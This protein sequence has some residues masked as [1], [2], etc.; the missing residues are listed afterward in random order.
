[1][2][3]WAE[4]TPRSF[5]FDVKAHP[6]FT[7]HPIDRRRLPS[8]LAQ[9]LPQPI[10]GERLYGTNLPPELAGEIERR[11]F[12]SLAPLIDVARLS[13][14]LVQFPPWFDATRGNVRHIEGLRSRYPEAPFSAEFR[15]RSWLLPER[16]QRVHDMLRA[17]Q[18]T[19]VVVDEP[20]VAQRG[21]V[22]L[23]PV[24]TSPKLAILRLHGQ[25]RAA[26][27]NPRATVAERFNYLYAPSELSVF[28]EAVRRLS[29][30][31]EGVHAVF[32][33]C[34][35]NFAILNAKGL[36]ALLHEG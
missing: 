18:L 31:A 10:A 24:V 33:N 30:E 27:Q 1:M 14:I 9:A 22:P 6:V 8:E 35:R 5:H 7:G 16:R 13:S 34:V 2:R 28:R 23:L 3:R 36:A 21:G 29:D 4:W 19:Y 25:N 11:Y 15:H 17:E 12:A 20:D 26:W 32:N